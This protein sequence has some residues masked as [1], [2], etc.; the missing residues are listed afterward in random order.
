VIGACLSNLPLSDLKP[1]FCSDEQKRVVRFRIRDGSDGAHQSGITLNENGT[2]LGLEC[3]MMQL[4]KIEQSVF[5]AHNACR[6][7]IFSL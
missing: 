4:D 7:Q 6:T 5:C 3:L 1:K 2:A